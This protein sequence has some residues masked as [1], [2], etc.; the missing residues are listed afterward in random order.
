ML[1]VSLQLVFVECRVGRADLLGKDSP[2]VGLVQEAVCKRGRGGCS[3]LRRCL[4]LLEIYLKRLSELL[5]SGQL[6]PS[7]AHLDL[8][9]RVLAHASHARKH[10]LR[11]PTTRAP[12][13]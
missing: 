9:D 3:L 10:T 7:A 6:A 8:G 11:P 5:R 12:Q 13:P 2:E 4:Q 1:A